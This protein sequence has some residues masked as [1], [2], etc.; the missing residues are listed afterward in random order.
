MRRG[1]VGS[2]ALDSDHTDHTERQLSAHGQ[3]RRDEIVRHAERIFAE[4]GYAGTRMADVAE[5]AG[6]TK[7]L[8]YWYFE[9]KEALAAEIIVDMRERLRNEQQSALRGM[10]D[11]LEMAYAST[12]ATVEFILE[13]ATLFGLTATIS[14]DKRWREASDTAWEVHAADASTL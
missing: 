4:R 2:S 3:D 11:F 10:S 12:V 5:A 9:N 1:A 13:N 6:I 8:V 7:G 14:T